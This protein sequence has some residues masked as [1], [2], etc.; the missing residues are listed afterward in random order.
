VFRIHMSF[1]RSYYE[2]TSSPYSARSQLA[3]DIDTEVCVIGAGFAGLWV[4]RALQKRHKSVALIERDRVANGASGCNGGF[5]SAGFNQS[6]STIVRRVGIDHARALYHLSR[7]GVQIVREEAALGSPG[8]DAVQGY[9][10]ASI[11]DDADAAKYSAE[12]YLREFDHEMVYW[13]ADRLRE[14]LRT[15]RYY[16]G[17]EEREAF[18]V[19]PLNLAIALAESI[20]RQGGKIYEKTEA[21]EADLDGVRK[22]VRTPRGVVR[23]EHVVFA[24][25]VFPGA[26]SP[27]LSRTIF[28]VATYL[29]VTQPL[30]EKLGDAIRYPGCVQDDRLAFNY[31]RALGDRLMWGGGISVNLKQPSNVKEQ[32]RDRIVSVYPQLAGVEIESAWTG[33]MGFSIHRMPQVGMLRPGAWIASAFG[34]QG[35]NTTAMAGELIASAI[36]DK[37]DRWRLFIPFGLVWA[38]GW[39]GRTFAQMNWWSR[40]LRDR[41]QEAHGGTNK[42]AA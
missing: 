7:M 15:E 22:I 27:E 2:E 32:L 35:L 20:E 1:S 4:A 17:L 10:R 12:W 13:P 6:L 34:G 41:I 30:G 5:V 40:K 23:A 16:A 39:F 14:Q 26:V 8:V 18:H 29:G 31:Y 24:T 28:P 36:A 42:S 11:H 19:H 3:H 21:I 38:G 25:N 9:L 37:D 33:I